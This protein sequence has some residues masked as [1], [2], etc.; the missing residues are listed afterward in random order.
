MAL[1][2]SP[3]LPVP[4]DLPE[5]PRLPSPW[6]AQVLELLEAAPTEDIVR[7]LGP[8][9]ARRGIQLSAAGEV[10]IVVQTDVEEKTCGVPKLEASLNEL[11]SRYPRLLSFHAPIF[12]Q[13]QF[14]I[15]LVY[16]S[17]EETSVKLDVMRVGSLR[18]VASVSF[19]T[20]G[21]SALPGV[22]FVGQAGVLEFSPGV[23]RHEIEISLISDDSWDSTV[24]FYVELTDPQNCTLNDRLRRVRVKLLD[25]DCFPTN[26]FRHIVER[27]AVNAL[28]ENIGD[29]HHQVGFWPLFVEYAKMNWTNPV[30]RLG[31]IKCILADLIKNVLVVVTL[32]LN[33]FLIDE[34]VDATA[35][36][37]Q[38]LQTRTLYLIIVVVGLTLPIGIRHILDYRRN[39]WKV[40]GASRK[41]LQ[42]NLMRRY[43]AYSADSRHLIS[44]S[45]LQQATQQSVTELVHKG[46]IQIFPILKNLGRLLFI[47][48]MQVGVD[49][50][51]LFPV[52]IFPIAAGVFLKLRTART[53]KVLRF[54]NQCDKR[55]VANVSRT[56]RHFVLLRDFGKR[57]EAV[58]RFDKTIAAYN[59]AYV[60]ACAVET[61]NLNFAPWVGGILI[62]IYVL[63]GG[64]KIISQSGTLS[65]LGGATLGEF[66]TTIAVLQKLGDTFTAIY[67]SL[68]SIQCIFPCLVDIVT[69]LTISTEDAACMAQMRGRLKTGMS[70]LLDMQDMHTTPLLDASVILHYEERLIT[71][72]IDKVPIRV[73]DLQM[74]S[75]TQH[76]DSHSSMPINMEFPQGSIF[77]VT[78]DVG[79]GK[80]QFLKSL[81]GIFMPKS[82]SIFISPHLSLLHVAASPDFLED[83]NLYLN[84]TFGVQG[85]LDGHPD[86]VRAV[87]EE[88]RLP[89]AII[90][91]AI[92]QDARPETWNKEFSARQRQL[93][94]L[95]RALIAN[96]EILVLETP[97]QCFSEEET[98]WLFGIFRD[99]VLDRGIKCDP[100]SFLSRHPRTVFMSTRRCDRHW[101]TDGVTEV[102]MSNK[103]ETCLL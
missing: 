99:F 79:S 43:L 87:L 2:A 19:A 78:G 13:V 76:T 62:A 90:A 52:F 44:E 10:D 38:D 75:I 92:D 9:L 101:A 80:A 58:Q 86:R 70:V 95:G 32:Q 56:A 59:N 49:P 11:Q 103:E 26:R 14:A 15:S 68:V 77:L 27:P 53:A 100:D 34:V 28:P 20:H 91:L 6:D 40:G 65:W 47:S 83:L 31:S 57:A 12:D 66:L 39:F 16:A 48:A 102:N 35:A 97:L 22:K 42:S 63:V 82:G 8:F 25:D 73:R 85:S 94:H 24:E 23:L 17:E 36:D 1:L 93:L 67:A 60:D 72:P 69:L 29:G 21:V 50:F 3:A 30:V 4:P 55:L 88:L 89:E 54:S 74:D 61:N 18:G 7:C 98:V 81:S 37:A 84:L 46:Y 45:F 5:T 33:M 51:G 64:Y 71:R 96:P 41:L